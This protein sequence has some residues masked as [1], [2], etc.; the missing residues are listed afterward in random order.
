MTFHQ[1]L[2]EWSQWVWPL[3]ANHLWQT[4]VFALMAWGIVRLFK[5]ST[6]RVRSC[7]WSIA[8]MKF[9]LPSA[10]LIVALEW[11]GTG[12]ALTAPATR[13]GAE[14]VSRIAQ[15]I[16]PIVNPGATPAA[17]TIVDPSLANRAIHRELYC[18]LSLFW[19]LGVAATL[20]GWLVRRLRF[21]LALRAGVEITAGR[22]AVA[23][24]QARSWLFPHRGFKLMAVPGLRDLGVWRIW[25]P[26]VLVP[27]GIAERLS[28]RELEAVMMHE[29]VHVMRYDN[30]RDTWRMLLS[31]LFWF[32][33]LIWL[34][35]RELRAEREV[36]CD[37]AVIRYNGDAITYATGLWKVA[38][39]GLGWDFAGISGA[40]GSTLS[41]RIKLML[42]AEGPT[43]LSPFGRILA[44]VTISGLFI[45]AIAIAVLTRSDVSAAKLQARGAPERWVPEIL[46]ESDKLPPVA[47][48]RF[49]STNPKVQVVGANAPTAKPL[50]EVDQGERSSLI[51]PVQFNNDDQ[52]PILVTEAEVEVGEPFDIT[53][54]FNPF[55]KPPRMM[56][57]LTFT[58]K[59]I[60]RSDQPIT[61]LTLAVQS[62]LFFNVGT[63]VEGKKSSLGAHES[64]TISWGHS[65]DDQ[66]Y[67]LDLIS[68][69]Q[70][71]PIAVT[72]DS[73]DPPGFAGF[74]LDRLKRGP[75]LKRGMLLVDVAFHDI[76]KSVGLKNY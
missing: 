18:L 63:G 22:E 20:T 16:L 41:K 6:A 13:A 34:I 43:K 47:A 3:V 54:I 11:S 50:I 52:I 74:G 2:A 39:Y 44:G 71:K 32:H 57:D 17:E 15:P 29:L 62:P 35:N 38:Q 76:T 68:N 19:G 75:R 23:F 69:M 28:D 27:D 65:V 64:A 14:I 67:A 33:P 5:R 61:G 9:L 48:P 30:L 70:L 10:L 46:P 31:C 58:L 4:T 51:M 36:I 1:T 8:L 53:T 37:E 73:V 25:R 66:E 21:R 26:I 56:R 40:A 45:I 59:L 12:I 60:N 49:S 7:I 24:N 72:H 42:N 55:S